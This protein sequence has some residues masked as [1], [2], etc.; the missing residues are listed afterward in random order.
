[1]EFSFNRNFLQ[2][3]GLSLLLH[4]LLLSGSNSLSEFRLAPPPAITLHVIV[5]TAVT[6]VSEASPVIPEKS[7]P[8]IP[9]AL[10]PPIAPGIAANQ[11]P[12]R[13][14]APRPMRAPPKIVSSESAQHFVS[15]PPRATVGTTAESPHDSPASQSQASRDAHLGTATSAA[16]RPASPPVS[17]GLNADDL[18]QYRMALGL[19]AKRFRHY[20]PLARERGW[21]GTV[22][23]ALSQQAQAPFPELTLHR[24]CG[25]QLLD[26]QALLMMKQAARTVAIPE[27]L[28][29]KNFHTKIPVQFSLE[30]E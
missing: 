25:R 20:P 12:T 18:R 28:R 7:P 24:S 1:M 13:K 3:L 8:P 6:A 23:V 16:P 21:E 9:T 27:G 2:A 30:D 29:G 4:A 10:P 17:D 26:E 19:A 15:P 11:A 14:P 22:E 5:N